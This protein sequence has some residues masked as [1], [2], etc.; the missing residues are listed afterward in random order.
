MQGPSKEVKIIAIHDVKKEG[1]AK[2]A[3]YIIELINFNLIRTFKRIFI[4]Y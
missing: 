2:Y 3:K 4:S 1:V